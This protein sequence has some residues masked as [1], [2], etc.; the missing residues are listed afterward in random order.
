MRPTSHSSTDSMTS[1]DS[2]RDSRL[3]YA[4]AIVPGG[5]GDANSRLLAAFADTRREDYLGPP[6]WRLLS[7][8]AEGP[9]L[10]DDPRLLYQDLLVS[11]APDRGINNGQPSLHARCIAA[12]APTV[13][14]TVLHVGAGSGY[15]SAIL[16]ALV[17]PAGVVLAYEIEADLAERAS[18]YLRHLPQVQVLARSASD[19]VLPF[20]DLIYVC[21]GATQPLPQWLDALKPGGRLIFPLTPN[22]GFGGM[23]MVTRLASGRYAA[24]MLMRVAFIPCIGARDDADSAVLSAALA[25]QP[26]D[27]VRSLRRSDKPDAT[28][29][30]VGQG[31]WLSTAEAV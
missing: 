31:W 18:A 14:D 20:A 1:Q 28:A 7:N 4:Q 22:E 5:G 10:T 13:G 30:C 12:G 8:P 26:F 17:G 29:W 21:A 11:I 15:Y 23:L 25:R 9:S 27:A 2:L 24:K 3:T 19:G 16:A 6:P